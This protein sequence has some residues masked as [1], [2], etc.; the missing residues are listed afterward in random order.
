MC[1]RADDDSASEFGGRQSSGSR[2]TPPGQQWQTASR[3][4]N[5][6]AARYDGNL[7][8]FTYYAIL[9]IE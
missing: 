4:N 3:E 6:P 8:P 2:G 5:L 9:L 7:H 1:K